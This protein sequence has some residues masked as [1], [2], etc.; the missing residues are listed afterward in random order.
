MLNSKVEYDTS[1]LKKPYIVSLGHLTKQKNHLL[2]INALKL[3]TNPIHCYILGEGPE[4]A[5]IQNLIQTLNLE[6]KVTLLGYI[7]KPFSILSNAE[8]LVL[9]SRY[10]GFPN[11]V[12]E[13]LGLGIPVVAN[14]CKGGINEII[15][16]NNGITSEFNNVESLS[17]SIEKCLSIKWNKFVIQNETIEKYSVEKIGYKY[18]QELS[19]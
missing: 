14:N 1:K 10:E 17:K 12:I 18:I 3:L 16:V 8:A 19:N 6:D 13:A 9:S 15:N 5:K 2:L 7:K 11:V 4:R